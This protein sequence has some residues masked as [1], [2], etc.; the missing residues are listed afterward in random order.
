MRNKMDKT[1]DIMQ[2]R[3]KQTQKSIPSAILENLMN[4]RH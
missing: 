2:N 3:E 1:L 4:H